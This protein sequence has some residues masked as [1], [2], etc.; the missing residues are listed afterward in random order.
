MSKTY[1]VVV[2]TSTIYEVSAPSEEAAME[3][4]DRKLKAENPRAVYKLQVAKEIEVEN[5]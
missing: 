4:I 3:V 5:G 1:F 2:E